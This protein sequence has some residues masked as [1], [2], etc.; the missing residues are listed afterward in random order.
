MC[1][2]RS[3]PKDPSFL[4]SLPMDPMGKTFPIQSKKNLRTTTMIVATTL[5]TRVN[6][7]SSVPHS[8]FA[9][10]FSE[11]NPE[12]KSKYSAWET[13]D[14]VFWTSKEYVVIR[15]DE[16]GLG[17]SPGLLDTMSRGTSECFFDVVEWAAEQPWS[18]GKVG[19]LGISYYAGSQWRVA[20]RRPKGLAA[21]VPWEGMTDY[22]R[23]RCRHGG[24]L[25]DNFIRFW[26]NRQVV[27][28]QYGKP[29]RAAS[30]WGEDTLE[31]DLLDE[32]LVANRNDQNKDNEKNRFLDDEY[33]ASKEFNLED[34]EVPLLSVANWGGILLHLRGREIYYYVVL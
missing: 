20:A 29:G 6:S 25:S 2:D 5:E 12:H 15:C 18:T 22:Y 30:K 1:I 13:P 26:W 3:P 9:K 8:F 32:I 11:V 19:L 17:Q 23:D 33:Y 16:R 34:I 10:S 24:I 7:N 28:N 31:G 14:P 4:L 21:I 27:T